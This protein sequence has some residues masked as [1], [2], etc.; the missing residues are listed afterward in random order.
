MIPNDTILMCRSQVV[1]WKISACHTYPSSFTPFVI[2]FELHWTVVSVN[3]K[4]EREAETTTARVFLAQFCISE[5]GWL[6]CSGVSPFLSLLL[7]PHVCHSARPETDIL[8][9]NVYEGRAHAGTH[10]QSLRTHMDFLYNAQCTQSINL[11]S[12]KQAKSQNSSTTPI[13]NI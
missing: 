8:K 4:W 11:Y 7:S 9:E 10:I 12:V 13:L 6:G 2:I 3:W 5:P 1:Y